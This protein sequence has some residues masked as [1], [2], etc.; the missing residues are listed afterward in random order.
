MNRRKGT[1]QSENQLP[2][3]ISGSYF[4]SENSL[5]KTDEFPLMLK[6]WNGAC[7]DL[8]IIIYNLN[9]FSTVNCIIS[10]LNYFYANSHSK[11]NLKKILVWV[12]FNKFFPE[13][14]EN[15]LYCHK[16]E[17]SVRI[18]L[19]ILRSMTTKNSIFFCF[20]QTLKI[21]TF[22]TTTTNFDNS[23]GSCFAVLLQLAATSMDSC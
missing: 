23:F 10:A 1:F 9:A 6:N 8:Y 15:L 2:E 17:N 4:P 14:L 19:E 20:Y 21:T 3:K 22:A 16:E 18:L 5:Q 11:H 12:H 13:V 7:K